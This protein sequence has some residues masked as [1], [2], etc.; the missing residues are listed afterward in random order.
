MKTN[1]KYEGN[2]TKEELLNNK[3]ADM[4]AA[5]ISG[6]AV[7]ATTK[8]FNYFVLNSEF[9]RANGTFV[10]IK[11]ASVETRPLKYKRVSPGVYSVFLGVGIYE[12][13]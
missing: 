11:N 3:V 13:V 1:P 10:C 4:N 12:Q 2:W 7:L 5:L 6:H 8:E 9:M